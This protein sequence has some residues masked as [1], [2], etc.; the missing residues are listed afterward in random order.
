VWFFWSSRE[1]SMPVAIEWRI[2]PVGKR[3]VKDVWLA[4]ISS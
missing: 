1:T 4:M 3:A 2:V